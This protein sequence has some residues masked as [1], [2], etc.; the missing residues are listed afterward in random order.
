MT[1]KS[2]EDYLSIIFKHK[3]E[4]EQI[5]PTLIA[6]M[7]NISGAAVTDMLK[8]LSRDGDIKYERYKGINL[9][10]KGEV[11]ARNI[12]RRH[13]IWEVFL[14]DVVG[15]PWEKIHDEAHKLEHS[16][17]DE[18]I[19]KLEVILNFPKYDPHG[20]PIPAKNGVMPKLPKHVPLSH[21]NAGDKCYVVRVNDFH[22]EFLNYISEIGIKLNKEIIV[23]EV[24]AFD[25]SLKIKINKFYFDISEKLAEK[26][27]VEIV[28]S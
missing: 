1:N 3:D 21:L 7:M 15:L 17:S 23:E 2:K 20:D 9:T 13:R 18:L 24:R 22:T 27:F 6:E 28:A 12:V 26:I 19:D 25:K 10:K 4:N 16:S 8:K 14:H 11:Y 5:K